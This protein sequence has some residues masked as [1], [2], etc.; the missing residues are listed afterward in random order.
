MS[1]LLDAPSGWTEPPDIGEPLA[2]MTAYGTLSQRDQAHV[3]GRYMVEWTNESVAF[4][5]GSHRVGIGQ[6]APVSASMLFVEEVSALAEKRAFTEDRDSPVELWVRHYLAL[7]L[8]RITAHSQHGSMSAFVASIVHAIMHPDAP[9]GGPP[10]G[11]LRD[12]N[13]FNR[14]LN[15]TEPVCETPPGATRRVNIMFEILDDPTLRSHVGV[16]LLASVRLHLG[17]LTSAPF[18]YGNDTMARLFATLPFFITD[19]PPVIYQAAYRREYDALVAAYLARLPGGAMVNPVAADPQP[20]LAFLYR[21]YLEA[22]AALGPE[23]AS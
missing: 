19:T 2:A 8:T 13:H 21:N 15:G 10:P 14:M 18:T 12:G 1:P 20:H 16:N 11:T 7:E 23:G 3:L 6:R 4:A 22:W 9:S 17:A 5:G